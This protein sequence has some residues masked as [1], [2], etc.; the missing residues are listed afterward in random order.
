MLNVNEIVKITKGVLR[1][2]ENENIEK[3][4]ID[5]RECDKETFF[6]PLTGEKVNAHTFIEEIKAIKGFFIDENY[7]NK[8]EII[9]N[10]IKKNKN[11]IIIEVEDVY[12]SLVKIATLNSKKN[13]NTIKIAV[14]G[15]VG[16][17]STR[18]MIAS[19]LET[20]Y[21]VIKTIRNYNS[22][23]GVSLMMLMTENKEVGIYEMGMDGLNQIKE[24]TCIVRPDYAV[25]TNIGTAHVGILGSRDNIL[26]AKMEIIEGL[27]KGG[28]L[29]INKD[30][31]KLK[32]IK[33]AENIDLIKYSLKDVKIISSSY[34]GVTFEYEGNQ[35]VIDEPGDHNIYN[36]LAAIKI[37]EKLGV[38]CE[39]IKLG[40]KKYRNFDRRFKKIEIKNNVT[41][42]DDSYNASLDSF[43]SGLD[44]VSKIKER[45]ILVL[46]DILELG[47]FS[48]K[49]H[50]ELAEYIDKTD[51]EKV[52]LYGTE[53][54]NTYKNVKKT[55]CY[56]YN[57][58]LELEKKLV[59]E[60][61]ENDIIYFKAS[62]GMKL[63]NIIEYVKKEY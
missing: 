22:E 28:S 33:V 31:D 37:A 29:I 16:K 21:K 36:A 44:I 7:E 26:K 59:S 57:N 55:N 51:A 19:V 54:E 15:S 58:Q 24:S 47:E 49:I 27:K 46:G 20:K 2:G 11:I 13:T 9:K 25:I 8:E 50:Q 52:F 6:I 5:S 10:M 63:T 40:I 39:D 30:N 48:K 61:K 62:N 17:T 4:A 34:G 23:I 32:K 18:E 53:I 1:N 56:Y 14:T 45:K 12:K 41:I 60:I 38:D 3:Y 35:Y 42:I 43:K